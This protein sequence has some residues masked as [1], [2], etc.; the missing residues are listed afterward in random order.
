MLSGNHMSA[1]GFHGDSDNQNSQEESYESGTLINELHDF[2][3]LSNIEYPKKTPRVASYYQANFS[4][5]RR[6]L[7]NS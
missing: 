6:L 5:R 3:K 1:V 2:L 7:L 4:E